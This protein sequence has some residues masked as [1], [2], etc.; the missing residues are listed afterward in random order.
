MF[1]RRTYEVSLAGLLLLPV[2]LFFGLMTVLGT[3]HKIDTWLLF[4]N[5]GLLTEAT[6]LE[7]D[8]NYVKYEYQVPDDNGHTVKV[9]ESNE[10]TIFVSQQL[11]P[12]SIVKIRYDP[13]DPSSALIEDDF[14]LLLIPLSLT[15]V[16]ASLYGTFGYFRALIRKYKPSKPVEST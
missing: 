11:Y 13:S 2:V 16:L 15:T 1:R 10:T 9:I 3:Y 5:R 7:V 12:G 8:D 6:V 4:R 14:V